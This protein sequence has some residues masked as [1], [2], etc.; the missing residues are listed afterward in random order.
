MLRAEKEAGT[1]LG[2]NADR[3]TANGQLLD[4]DSVNA[5]VDH[6]LDDQ[7]AGKFIFDGYPRTLGQG[8]FLDQTLVRRGTPLEQV[9]YLEADTET[10]RGRIERRAGCKSCGKILSLRPGQTACDCGGEIF[11]RTDDTDEVLTKRIAE[12]TEKTAPL[13]GF[14]EAQGIL[15]KFDATA[16][17]DEVFQSVKTAIFLK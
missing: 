17:A 2:Q 4:D 6:W 13:V 14:Y 9:I 10:L 5:L 3:I 8:R 1:E 7:P 12:Y 15:A 16:P 11:R